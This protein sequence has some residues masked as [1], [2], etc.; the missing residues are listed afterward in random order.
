M[1]ILIKDAKNVFV[2]RVGNTV[3]YSLNGQIVKRT[4]GKSTKKATVSQ[5]SARQQ[6]TVIAKF[7]N[8]VLD[9]INIGFEFEAKR[10]RT[11][12]AHNLATSYNRRNAIAGTY[13]DQHINFSKA[14]LSKGKIPV[15]NNISVKV[16]ENGLEFSWDRDS[17]PSGMK[18]D[19]RVMLMAYSP[20]KKRAI[21]I[22][23]GAERS[24]GAEI[25]VITEFKAPLVLETYVSF[26]SA[27]YKKI[28]NS[29]YT[30]QVLWRK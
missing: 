3:S 10:F 30:G 28:S 6:T 4:I 26:I 24:E 21:C 16:I 29:L 15:A 9:Y 2:G 1:A 27:D 8:S 22:T 11:K 19:D 20:E 23:S 7:L 18:P 13:P 14:L 25:L 5:L 17:S 12:N